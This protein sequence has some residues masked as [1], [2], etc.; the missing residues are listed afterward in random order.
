M[1]TD[2]NPYKKEH[3]RQELS[4][5]LNFRSFLA[6]EG[7]AFFTPVPVDD[8][9]TYAALGAPVAIPRGAPYSE[10]EL[11]RIAEAVR[12]GGGTL[13]LIEPAQYSQDCRD[14]LEKEAPGQ[15]RP[16]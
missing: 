2:R 4:L 9:V 13:T 6:G 10:D 15:I 5:E 8:L 3:S 7:E 16:G 1:E 14:C 12:K 11:K